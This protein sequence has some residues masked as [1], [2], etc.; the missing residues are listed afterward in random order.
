MGRGITLA[1]CGLTI[2][3]I[4][5]EA[6]KLL[7]VA[8]PVS[9]TAACPACGRTSASVHSRYQ[10]SLSDL[11]SQGRRVRVTVCARRFR[12]VVTDCPQRI[13]AERLE[14]TVVGPFARRTA[15]LEGIVH[16]LGL[17]LGGRPGQSFARRLLLPVSNDTLL[18]VVRRRA[19]K[20]AEA[21]RVI[22]IDDWAWKRGHRYGTII[23]DL[24]RRRI[25]DILPNREAATVTAWLADRPSICVI[26]RDRGVGYKQAATDGRP[27]AIQVADRWHLMENA[28]AAFLTI[29]QRSMQTI[30]KAIGNGVVDPALLSSAE[31]RQHAGWLRREKENAAITAL[32]KQG[33][34]IKEIV[35]QTGHSRGLVRQVVR[36]GRTDV[37][38]NRTSSLEPFLTQLD[39]EWVDGCHNGATLWRRVK[40]TGFIGSL[41][42]VAEW[43]TRRR[44]EEGPTPG[45]TR[46]CKPPSARGIAR[47]MTTERDRLSKTIARTIAIIEGAV[48]DLVTAR[49]LMDRFHRLI[50]GRKSADLET[51]I[52]DAKPSQ[53][54]SF[55]TGIIQDQ[56]AVKAAL[57]EPWSNGQ[58]E[59][60][61]TKLKLVK[62]QMYGRAN[63][64]LLRA[65]LL[66]AT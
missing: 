42:V 57:T 1:P 8:R 24:E 28:S 66:G 19:A 59:G 9:K 56:A 7:I 6:D 38:R 54:A 36:G 4:E 49:D 48:P 3:R 61:N 12:C 63:L 30:R 2:E 60:Q 11:P 53:M 55:A 27:E 58:T 17:A 34:A 35:R 15:R 25:I 52:A 13:F 16:H 41:R 22:G 29:V 33:V 20:L 31:L 45:N 39:K 46:P 47:M 32:T 26:A 65:R 40:A 21:T 62:R 43:T 44:K 50:Q 14:A 51:W 5:T 10:R 37:F 23:C 64:D 18:R